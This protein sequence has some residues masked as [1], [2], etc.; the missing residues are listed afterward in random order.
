MTAALAEARGAGV[1]CMVF[2]DLYLEWI[3]SYREQ[4]LATTG[5][6]PVFPLWGLDTASWRRQ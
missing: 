1:E 2:G 5:L 3:R 6:A 4:R